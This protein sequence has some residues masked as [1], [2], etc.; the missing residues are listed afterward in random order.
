MVH[1]SVTLNNDGTDGFCYCTAEIIKKEAKQ[2]H[3]YSAI[4][5]SS[6]AY[7]QDELSSTLIMYE[8]FRWN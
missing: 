5:T 6:E 3:M 1:L 4:L 7:R 8:N 2:S